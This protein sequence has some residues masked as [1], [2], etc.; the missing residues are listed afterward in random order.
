[1]LYQQ[2]Q[3]SNLYNLFKVKK[4]KKNIPTPEKNKIKINK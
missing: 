1:M 3:V 2:W 4:I